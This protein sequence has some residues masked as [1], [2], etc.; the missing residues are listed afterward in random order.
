MELWDAYDGN[1]QKIK[2]TV[3]IRGEPIPEGLYHLVCSILVR[4]EDGSYL[5]MQRDIR[6]HWGGMWEATAGGG[7]M[8]GETPTECAIR[9]LFEET[10]LSE[11]NLTELGR[12]VHHGRQT[13]FVEYLCVTGCDKNAVRLREGETKDYRWVSREELVAMPKT[14][15]ITCRIQVF[16]E[17]LQR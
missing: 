7:A 16:L 6:K 8:Q 15:L 11:T 10:G 14:E 9:E 5:L 2:D 3:L 4:H 1:F 13:L 12:V 17:K